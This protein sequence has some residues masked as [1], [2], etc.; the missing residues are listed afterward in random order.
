VGGEMKGNAM[1]VGV[2]NSD[3]ATPLRLERKIKIF[4]IS[5]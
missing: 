1:F 2:S 5:N 4:L 3:C